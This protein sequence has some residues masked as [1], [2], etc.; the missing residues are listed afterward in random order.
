MKVSVLV[1]TYNRKEFLKRCLE[2]ILA[3]TF[4]H[5]ELILVDNGSAD[6]TSSVCERFAKLDNRVKYL[7]VPKNIGISHGRNVALSAARGEFITMVDDD[8]FCDPGM[9]EFLVN[10]AQEH[11][12][13]ISMCGSLNHFAD[14]VEPRFVFDELYI[15]NKE[16]AVWELLKRQLYN[17]AP[18]GKLFKT[19]L[20]AGISYPED[21]LIDDIHVI[22]KLFLRADKVAIQGLP[23]YH[24]R[25]HDSNNS[26]F[27]QTKKFSPA[28]LTEYLEMYAVRKKHIIEAIPSLSEQ[29][30]Y[31]EWS[32]MLSMCRNI[33]L[34]NNV[35]CRQH[36]QEMISVLHQNKKAFLESSF[37]TQ[38]E[39]QALIDL[40][41][42]SH[43]FSQSL[44]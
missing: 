32:F 14:K 26:K 21:K 22:Y 33:I 4:S 41:N 7:H 1:L 44:F 36:F 38:E 3:Q 16:Q 42:S 24:Y 12:A 30:Q 39:K 34:H 25:M 19:E 10:L 18:G 37:A 17:V 43:N 31:S 2:S 35:E 8:D 29:A 23:L 9:L 13:D 28:F 27:T 6:G 40:L 20:F 11:S 5:F 15:F